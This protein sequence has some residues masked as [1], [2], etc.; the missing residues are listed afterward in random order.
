MRRSKS[1]WCGRGEPFGS[2]RNASCRTTVRVLV[3]GKVF[4]RPGKLKLTEWMGSTSSAHVKLG[5]S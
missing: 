5:R 4:K 1:Q 2:Q 3:T